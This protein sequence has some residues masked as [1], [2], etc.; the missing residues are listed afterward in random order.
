MEKRQL[1]NKQKLLTQDELDI[2]NALR[3]IED[4][5]VLLTLKEYLNDFKEAQSSKQK[6]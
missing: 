5:S 2:I 6:K 3:E 4:E 1:R